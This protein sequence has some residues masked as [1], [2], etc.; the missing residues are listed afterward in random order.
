[1]SNA[2]RVFV[3]GVLLC[4]GVLTHASAQTVTNA[5]KVTLTSQIGRDSE[6]FS[7]CGVHVVAI[8]SRPGFWD[9]HTFTLS[10]LLNTDFGVVKAGKT[11]MTAASAASGKI[12][13]A[14][15]VLPAPMEFWIAGEKEGKALRTFHVMPANDTG[16]IL[17]GLNLHGTLKAIIDLTDGERMHFSMRYPK[18]TQENVVAFS[19]KLPKDERDALSACLIGLTERMVS[20]AMPAEPRPDAGPD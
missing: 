15:A 2:R 16:A 11:T 12:N 19:Q 17:G 5:V 13:D 3:A 4:L 8:G 1:M 6:G 9:A 18:Q 10:L 7:S 14:K 20:K